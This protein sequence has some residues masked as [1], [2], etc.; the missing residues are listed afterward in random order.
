MTFPPELRGDWDLPV[1][2]IDE[3]AENL[4]VLA[5]W[6]YLPKRRNRTWVGSTHEWMK[7]QRVRFEDDV[8]VQ[9]TVY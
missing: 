3:L 4:E 6:G 9:V 1:A 5:A 7:V 8:D 2:G